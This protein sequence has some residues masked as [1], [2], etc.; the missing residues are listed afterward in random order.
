MHQLQLFSIA[1]IHVP[2]KGLHR[3]TI[4]ARLYSSV[5]FPA[6]LP[7]SSLPQF[8]TFR[9]DQYSERC[10]T[11]RPN[12]AYRVLI[13]MR[14]PGD[15]LH[16]SSRNEAF[17]WTLLF[18][19]IL[20]LDARIIFPYHAVPGYELRTS[21]PILHD[22]RSDNI[23]ARYIRFPG[24]GVPWRSTHSAV[25]AKYASVPSSVGMSPRAWL[26]CLKTAYPRCAS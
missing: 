11:Y 26:S 10:S 16:P 3:L 13:D 15:W 21:E 7:T 14:N 20:D 19:D 18:W 5:G 6:A 22:P 9:P 17:L 23:S 1:T 25:S 4:I 8:Y 12:P 24:D 2:C